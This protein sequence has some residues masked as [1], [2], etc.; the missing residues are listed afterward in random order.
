M[1][2]ASAHTAANDN[3]K[4]FAKDIRYELE[5]TLIEAMDVE[6]RVRYR[7]D[8]TVP[9][10]FRYLADRIE[11]EIAAEIESYRGEAA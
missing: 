11:S 10:E 7:K 6:E 5:G 1:A 8:G 9:P 2:R 4:T 3:R